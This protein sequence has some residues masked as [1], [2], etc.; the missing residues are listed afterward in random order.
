VRRALAT[1][2]LALAFGLAAALF[3]TEPLWVP[4]ATLA[5]LAAGSAAWVRLG[6]R[7]VRVTRTLGARRVMEEEPVTILLEVIAGRIGLPPSQIADPLMPTAVALRGGTGGGRVR[8]EA[9]FARRGRRVLAVPRVVIADPLGLATRE[10]AARPS[11]P[12]DE[13]LV[14]P[15]IEPVVA[16]P[17]GGDATRIT[18]RGLPALGIEIELDGIRPLREGTPAGRMYWPAVARGAE[19]QERFLA[20]ASESRPVVVLDPRGAA[21]EAALDAAVRAAAS[22]ARALAQ[23]GG[24]SV[25]LPGDRRPVELGETLAGWAHMHARLAVLG[26]GSGPALA[27]LAQRRGPVVFVS[28]RMRAQMPQAL[29]PAHGATRIV[30]VPGTLAD[31]RPMFSV[32][33]CSGYELSIPRGGIGRSGRSGPLGRSAGAARSPGPSQESPA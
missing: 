29:G 7:G 2:L 22:L 9:R 4:A 20:A 32:A 1:G 6:A 33:G 12:S 30:V 3:D 25:L 16:A 31:R 15:R 19:P 13:L 5:L 17:G 14:L 21:S 24:C 11:P 23:A 26:T 18:R 27:S 8:I 28:A 10:V